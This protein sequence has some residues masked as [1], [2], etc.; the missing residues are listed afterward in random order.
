MKN[1]L[2]LWDL[3]PTFFSIILYT[4]VKIYSP[5]CEERAGNEFCGRAYEKEKKIRKIYQKIVTENKIL[6]RPEISNF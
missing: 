5:I 6:K 4:L 2:T 1:L 3:L